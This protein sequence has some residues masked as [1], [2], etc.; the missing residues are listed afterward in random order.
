MTV[1]ALTA[2]RTCRIYQTGKTLVL[3]S[4]TSWVD[5]RET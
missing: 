3:I 4:V 5:P 1:V 2:L